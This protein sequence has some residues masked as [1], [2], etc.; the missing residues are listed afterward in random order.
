M[1]VLCCWLDALTTTR[2]VLS[3]LGVSTK[4]LLVLLLG[5]ML[6]DEE[7]L[8]EVRGVGLGGMTE[9]SRLV[10]QMFCCPGGVV[11]FG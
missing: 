5:E 7:D 4:L 6:T 3:R 10:A 2:E 1:G 8:V 11:S 9:P